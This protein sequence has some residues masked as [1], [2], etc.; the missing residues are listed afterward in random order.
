MLRL[1]QRL[2]RS[3]LRRR[4]ARRGRLGL[5]RLFLAGEGSGDEERDAGAGSLDGFFFFFGAGDAAGDS[6]SSASLAEGTQ[7][8][9]SSSSGGVARGGAPDFSA[10]EASSRVCLHLGGVTPG[11][12]GERKWRG[13]E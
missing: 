7:S 5:L 3:G 11:R 9:S 12:G 1:L 10:R 13:R 8:T 4:R 2:R 6:R